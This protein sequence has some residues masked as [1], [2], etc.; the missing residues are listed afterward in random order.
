MTS[1]W[2]VGRNGGME[3]ALADGDGVRYL[4]PSRL[5]G[6]ETWWAMT[7]HKS[8]GSEFAHAVV[9]L[10]DWRRRYSPANCSTPR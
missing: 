1:A 8:Q 10:P 3:V 5:E 6:V 4:A 7:V 9:S 2:S